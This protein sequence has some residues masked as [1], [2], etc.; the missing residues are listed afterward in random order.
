VVRAPARREVIAE[1]G[2]HHR[3]R[4]E[5]ADPGLER[6]TLSGTFDASDLNPFLTALEK[7][8]PL[9]VKRKEGIVVLDRKRGK[10]R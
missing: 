6:E 10:S 7:I 5:F 4:F 3:L 8:L 9:K 2:R 1:L